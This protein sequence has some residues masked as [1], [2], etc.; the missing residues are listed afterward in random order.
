VDYMEMEARFRQVAYSPDIIPWLDTDTATWRRLSPQDNS[1]LPSQNNSVKFTTGSKDVKKQEANCP[2][3]STLPRLQAQITEGVPILHCGG[4]VWSLGWCPGPQGEQDQYL[5][6]S[7]HLTHGDVAYGAEGTAGPGLL[8]LW[9]F[10]RDKA[11]QLVRPPVFSQGIAHNYGRVW[12]LEWC[13]SGLWQVPGSGGPRLG[14]LAAACSDGTVRLFLLHHA[15]RPGEMWERDADRT[16]SPDVSPTG[17]HCLSLSWY[18]GPGHRYL[19]A[20]FSSGLVCLWE[21]TTSSPLL[22]RQSKVLPVHSWL[23]HSSSTTSVALC[24]SETELPQYAVTGGTDRCYKFWDLRDTSV[25][26]QEVKRG[27]VTD[28]CWVPGFPA[29][30]VTYDDV[31]QQT[32]TNTVVTE[33]DSMN[34]R[35]FPIISQNSAVWS[36]A[37]SPWL[38]SLAVGSAAGELILYVFPS[39]FPRTTEQHRYYGK[40]REYVYRTETTL[41]CDLDTLACSDYSSLADQCTL[42]FKDMFNAKNPRAKEE[43]A[44]LRVAETMPAEPLAGYPLTSLNRVAW[45]PN[46]GAQSW[47]ASGNQAGLVRVHTLPSLNTAE[48]Q[49]AVKSFLKKR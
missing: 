46:L 26:L 41:T 17:G 16:L 13:P 1:Y 36:Q 48:V 4:P 2:A 9:T 29:V 6:L 31:Y 10:H 23:A 44:R 43:Q 33:S 12:G 32:H 8:Q 20:S 14:G 42:H 25:P 21:L 5:A 47:L 19:A 11:G 15:K 49:A 24:P 3:H 7:S 39:I 28:V 30:T 45:N 40:R 37:L 38:G 35:S 18:R 27:L 34:T 22:V